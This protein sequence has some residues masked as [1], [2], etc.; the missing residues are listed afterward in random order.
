MKQVLLR[1]RQIIHSQVRVVILHKEL[2]VFNN[3]CN[4]KTETMRYYETSVWLASLRGVTFYSTIF[5]VSSVRT[6]N[7][8]PYSLIQPFNLSLSAAE[9]YVCES[10]FVWKRPGEMFEG[11][12]SSATKSQEP[13]DCSAIKALVV[14]SRC[15]GT[16]GR[17]A[18]QTRCNC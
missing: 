18:E 16:N 13:P 14:S 12:Y 4:L 2:T 8:T 3:C 17:V 1:K 5:T 15:L 11:A 6:W 7:F 10:S 9:I